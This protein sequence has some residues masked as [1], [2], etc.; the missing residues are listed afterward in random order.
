MTKDEHIKILEENVR[1]LQEQ[2]NAAYI[3]IEE[4]RNPKENFIK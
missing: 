4:L 2:L 3:R 1:Q